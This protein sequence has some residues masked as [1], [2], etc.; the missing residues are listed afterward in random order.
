MELE[1]SSPDLDEVRRSSMESQSPDIQK[2]AHR[3]YLDS[4]GSPDKV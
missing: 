3:L 1:Y 2:Y 4:P